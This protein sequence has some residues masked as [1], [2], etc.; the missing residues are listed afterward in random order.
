MAREEVRVVI[1]RFIEELWNQGNLE[2]A[3][4]LLSAELVYH[5]PMQTIQGVAD[6]RQFVESVRSAFPNAQFTYED[7]VVE[8]D[9]AALRWALEAAHEGQ[10]P[11]VPIPPTGFKLEMSGQTAFRLEEGKIAEIWMETDYS[12]FFRM[13]FAAIAAVVGAVVGLIV[14]AGLIGRLLRRDSGK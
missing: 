3:D 7:L 8:G 6:Y 13:A 1:K 14:V 11:A 12:P 9:R 10:M 5:E 4:E 2:A